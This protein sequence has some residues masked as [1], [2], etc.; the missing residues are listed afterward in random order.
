[1]NDNKLGELPQVDRLMSMDIIKECDAYRYEKADALR[2]VLSDIRKAVKSGKMDEVPDAGCIARS[3]A[4]LAKKRSRRGIRKLI[5]GTGVI[6]HSNFG[7]A[8]MS[9]AAAD[10]A[11]SAALSFSTL[12]YDAEKKSRG[13]RTALIEEQLKELTDC[14]ASLIVN[15]NAA[16]VL[17]ILSTVA[18]NGNVPVSRGELVEI[19]GGFRVP[20]IISSCKA[21]LRAVGTTNKTRANDYK[22]AI[23]KK[24]KAL[25]K[26]HTSNFKIT[27]FSESVSIKE[28]AELGNAHGIPVVYDIGSGALVDLAEYG[29]ND[30]PC[31]RQSLKDGADIVS[32]SGD[33]LL[34]GPQCGIILGSKKYIQK[35]KDNPLYRALRVGKMT[36]AALTATLRVYK[37]PKAAKQEIPALAMLSMPQDTL[38][39]RAE[40]LCGMISRCGAKAVVTEVKS[41]A[42]GGALPGLELLS[43]AVSPSCKMS[44]ALLDE[45]LRMLPVPIIGRIEDENLLLDVRTLFEEDFEYIA[46][47]LGNVAN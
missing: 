43:Y 18:K 26:V 6:L 39:E 2:D 38:R 29:I 27:G 5:N 9:K 4:E 1:M 36:I 11:R 23:G 8:C 15:N 3:A 41:V 32:F 42:G 17:L 22:A 47:A 30:E 12:E 21:N 13:S 34:G 33:K 20:E 31:V 28:L 44:A 10:A 37:D 7:R 45:R 24:T 14:E 46:S 16:A 25:L 40:R 19:G 35:M